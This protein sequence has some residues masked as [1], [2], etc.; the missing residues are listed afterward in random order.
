MSYHPLVNQI[1]EVLQH[2]GVRFTTFEHEPVL[3][4]AEA[5]ALR[6]G[7]S[8]HEGAKA[9]IV[10]GQRADGSVV[11]AMFV[12]PGDLRFNSK[13]I[14][15][16]WSIKKI[17]LASVEEVARITNGVLPGGVPPFGNL[18]Q[19]PVWVD[20]SLLLNKRMIF[21]AG[22][23]SF[24]IGMHTADWQKIVQPTVADLV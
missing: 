15:T 7:Y 17:S 23:R 16:V 9:L 10:R 18:F 1:I 4:S 8:L 21:N 13:K 14:K 12:L 5:A 24:S 6:D 20:R 3:T 22:D 11:F 19:L 2:Q